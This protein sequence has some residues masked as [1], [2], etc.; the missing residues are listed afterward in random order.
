MSLYD[1]DYDF[2]FCRFVST[3]PARIRDGEDSRWAYYLFFYVQVVMPG[4][5][6]EG[7]AIRGTAT[8]GLCAKSDS[9]VRRR[10][11]S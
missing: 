10:L 5:P 6:L 8:G 4:L 11:H 2:V 1:R 9:E 3:R 7:K